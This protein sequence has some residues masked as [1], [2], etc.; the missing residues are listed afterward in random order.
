MPVVAVRCTV[1]DGRAAGVRT[2]GS[3]DLCGLTVDD[4]WTEKAEKQL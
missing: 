2:Q 4:V 1:A 3:H